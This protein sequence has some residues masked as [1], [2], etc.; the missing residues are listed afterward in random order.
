[1]FTFLPICLIVTTLFSHQ[2]FCNVFADN[3]KLTSFAQLIPCVKLQLLYLKNNN[4][5]EIPEN[6]ADSSQLQTLELDEN[7]IEQ[8]PDLAVSSMYHLRTLSLIKTP[9]AERQKRMKELQQKRI[10]MLGQ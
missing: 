3:N 4:I 1:M 5:G 9:F 7:P 10:L 6:I 2:L 8:I